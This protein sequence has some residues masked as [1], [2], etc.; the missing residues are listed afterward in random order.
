MRPSTLAPLV[1]ALACFA[2]G[3]GSSAP[4]PSAGAPATSAASAASSAGS[5]APTATAAAPAEPPAQTHAQKKP[6]E[7]Y[8]GCREVVTVV[9]A[10]D[11]AE[12]GAP[13]RTIAGFASSEGARRAD[14]TQTVWLVDDQGKGLIKVHVTRPMK[15]VEIGASCRT[16][17]AR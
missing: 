11:P 16:L 17:D 9:F 3:G 4:P 15:R 7:I 10:E 8:N 1:A 12:A 6:L 13:K 5:S 2:C 14:G